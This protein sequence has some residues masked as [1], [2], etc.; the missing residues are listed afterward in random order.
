MVWVAA[1]PPPLAIPDGIPRSLRGVAYLALEACTGVL[2]YDLIFFALHVT[3][4]SVGSKAHRVHHTPGTDLR[5]RDVLTHSPID[6]A[7]QVLTN[8]AVQRY[9]PWGAS[10][11]RCARALHNVLV[12]WMLTESHTCAPTPRIARRWFAGVRRHRAHHEGA[13]FYQQFFGYA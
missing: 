4:H 8:I 10:K 2:S 13:Q 1:V 3:M 7:L 9:T 5:A 12:T 6:G 11:S